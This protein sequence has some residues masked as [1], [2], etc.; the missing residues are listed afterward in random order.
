M[1]NQEVCIGRIQRK[2]LEVVF[3]KPDQ[4]AGPG[5]D[6]EA[7]FT[8]NQK[9]YHRSGWETITLSI[10]HRRTERPA[11]ALEIEKSVFCDAP[12][13]PVGIG[14]HLR[15]PP[16]GRS[17]ATNDH[18]VPYEYNLILICR[19]PE[20]VLP[21]VESEDTCVTKGGDEDNPVRV[22]SGVESI[23]RSLP[24]E[25][26]D[27]PCIRHAGFFRRR[28]SNNHGSGRV[29]GDREEATLRHYPEGPRRIFLE[30]CDRAGRRLGIQGNRCSPGVAKARETAEHCP[31]PKGTGFMK[32]FVDGGDIVVGK[33]LRRRKR[34]ERNTVK[35]AQPVCGADP[36]KTLGVLGQSG[37]HA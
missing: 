7:I 28:I 3:D 11:V 21:S 26:D 14:P 9:G 16:A 25:P 17:P 15:C 20:G 27:L 8:I 35:S 10:E 34:R 4:A 37:Y 23:E 31:D 30:V 2:N 29:P 22:M 1:S 5:A 13:I 18:G 32:A 6:P 12:E 24:G 36:E 19:Y 33:A